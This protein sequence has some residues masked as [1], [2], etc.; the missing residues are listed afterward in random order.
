MNNINK[1][2]WEEFYNNHPDLFVE[3]YI[4]KLFWWQKLYLRLM[5][6]G[7]TS[8]LTEWIYRKSYYRQ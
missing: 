5:Y 6:K 1:E 8:K 3:N 2:R 4:G 7:R